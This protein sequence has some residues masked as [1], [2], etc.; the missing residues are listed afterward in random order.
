MSKLPEEFVKATQPK[1]TRTRKTRQPSL[2]SREAPNPREV[3]VQLTDD[4]LKALEEARQTLHHTGAP[5][6]IEQMIHR[7]IAEWMLRART[8]VKAAPEPPAARE[9]FII[10]RLRELAAAP[11]RTWREL[12]N[13]VRQLVRLLRA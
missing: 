13:N 1:T 10:T 12:S 11:L 9:L 7:V 2:V 6:T 8:V 3:L 5:I 4:E